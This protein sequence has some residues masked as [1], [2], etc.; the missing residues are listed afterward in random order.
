VG[1]LL[2][3]FVMDGNLDSSAAPDIDFFRFSATPR[4]IV[5]VDQEGQPTGK[6]TLENSLLGFFDSNCNF[7]TLNDDSNNLNSHLDITVPDDGVFIIATTAYPDFGFT[8]GGF[9]SYQLTVTPPQFIN[10]ISGV[11]ADALNGKPLRGDA[12][13]FAFVRLLRCETFGCFDVNSQNSGSDGSFHFATD[14]NGGALRVGDYMIIAS[15]DQ[16]QMTE[17]E[18]FSMGEGEDHNTGLIALNSYPIRFSDTQVCNVPAQGGLCDFSVK[19]TNGLPTKFSGKVWSIVDAD[20]LRSF[21]N[22]SSFQADSPQDI[23]LGSGK[24]TI[25]RFRFMVR[26]SVP[27]GASIC[28]TVFAGKNPSPFF[29]AVG[30][31]FLFCFTKG[32][33]GFTLM[34]DQEMQS[35]L[36]HMPLLEVAPSAAPS[37]PKK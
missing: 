26:G 6:G 4:S 11:I 8:G 37:L 19:V 3:S 36:Q 24:S 14:F 21:I 22:F 16:Y 35:Q 34:S 32:V 20:N 18:I 9:G 28:A 7:I 23:T 31:S 1:A 15:A 2:D 29:N 33:N 25:V 27:N 13:P 30:K 5:A 12:A 10:S 17:T